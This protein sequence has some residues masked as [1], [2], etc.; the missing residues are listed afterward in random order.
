M[1][2]AV[3][4][5]RDRIAIS[6]CYKAIEDTIGQPVDYVWHTDGGLVQ[7]RLY[8]STRRILLWGL[9]ALRSDCSVCERDE[10]LCEGCGRRQIHSRYL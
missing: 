2:F 3:L 8:L 4:V 5:F 10:E 1:N 7:I 6:T 9:P